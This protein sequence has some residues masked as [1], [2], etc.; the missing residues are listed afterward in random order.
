MMN[1]SL[2]F[3]VI[4]SSLLCNLNA[5]N[6]KDIPFWNPNLSFEQRAEDIVSRLTLEE[7]VGQMLNHAPAIER[8]NIPAYDWWNEVLHGVARTPFNTTSYPQAIAM[9]ATWDTTSLK[10][11]AHYSA[12]EGRAAVSYTHLDVY[13]RQIKS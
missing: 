5:Q 6:T 2:V 1:R 8:Y 7:K 11:M 9:A 13:K 10:M 4:M 3:I 12:L